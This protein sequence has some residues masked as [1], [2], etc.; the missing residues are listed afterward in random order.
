MKRRSPWLTFAACALLNGTMLAE[1]APKKPD[2]PRLALSMAASA[3]EAEL[4]KRGLSGDHTISS[5]S[6]VSKNGAAYYVAHVEPPI[7]LASA[8]T[9]GTRVRLTFH[10]EMDGRV[11]T[12]HAALGQ[13][14]FRTL[15]ST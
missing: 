4:E 9:A 2:Q 15:K 14:D 7:L 11:T 5:V 3:V 8:S 1:H 10:V 13:Q 12:E 6:M